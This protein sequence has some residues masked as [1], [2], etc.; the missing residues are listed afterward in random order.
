MTFA[1]DISPR[2]SE[3]SG[4][5]GHSLSKLVSRSGNNFLYQTGGVH[6]L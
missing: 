3:R 2:H 5:E 6:K 1:K 4:E